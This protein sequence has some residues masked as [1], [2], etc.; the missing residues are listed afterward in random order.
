MLP[1]IEIQVALQPDSQGGIYVDSFVGTL[2]LLCGVLVFV[3]V[4]LFSS[5]E[6]L[7]TL[8]PELVFFLCICMRGRCKKKKNIARGTTDPW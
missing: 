5:V 2:I 1:L 8:L 6:F 7:L 4:S 3:F